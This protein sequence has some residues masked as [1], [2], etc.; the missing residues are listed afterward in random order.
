MGDRHAERTAPAVADLCARYLADHA[1]RKRARSAAE[2]ESLIRQ[3]I[4]PH[5]GKIRVAA[6][7]RPE[8]E[9]F[10]R[11]DHKATPTRANRALSL[12]TNH[13][14]P[15]HRMGDARTGR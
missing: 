14:E 8:V 2:D 1:S 13:V 12:L 15:R 11:R 4:I 6:V 9:R 3:L 5:L 10:H 7:L